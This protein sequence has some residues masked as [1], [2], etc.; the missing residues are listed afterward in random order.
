[1]KTYEKTLHQKDTLS[2]SRP[3]WV[4]CISD[5]RAYFW[6]SNRIYMMVIIMTMTM[7]IS[8]LSLLQHIEAI[9]ILSEYYVHRTPRRPAQVGHIRAPSIAEQ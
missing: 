9:T 4:H 5:I 3:F 1:M 2:F 7:M 6:A 8:K